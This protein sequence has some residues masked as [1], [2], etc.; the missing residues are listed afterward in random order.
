MTFQAFLLWPA[1]FLINGVLMFWGYSLHHLDSGWAWL[2]TGAVALI[3]WAKVWKIAFGKIK[4]WL[5][6]YE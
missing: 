1:Q 4:Q 2:I 5:G 3:F 6:I